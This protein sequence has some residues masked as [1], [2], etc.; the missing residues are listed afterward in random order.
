MANCYEMK[1]GQVYECRECGL[2]LKV[3]RECIECGPFTDC[4]ACEP[5][6]FHCCDEEMTLR[7]PD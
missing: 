5:C 7:T 6:S 2:E 1:E 3:I 4:L